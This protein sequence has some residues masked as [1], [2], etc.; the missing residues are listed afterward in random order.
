VGDHTPTSTKGEFPVENRINI[1]QI[2][3]EMFP[4]I[5]IVLGGKEYTVASVTEDDMQ[6]FSRAQ[7]N[8]TKLS[9]LLAKLVGAEPGEFAK[10]DFRIIS[11]AITKI[12]EQFNTQ[13]EAVAQGKNAPSGENA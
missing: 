10:T 5:T 6:A 3:A 1:D 9:E 4:A 2:T 7:E 12:I 8:N 11:I 13:V